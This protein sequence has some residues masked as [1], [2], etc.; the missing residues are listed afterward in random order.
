MGKVMNN[1]KYANFRYLLDLENF[2][3][4]EENYYKSIFAGMYIL[5]VLVKDGFAGLKELQEEE[6]ASLLIDI[7]KEVKRALNEDN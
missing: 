5:M 6:R 4:I 3:L 1:V 2:T 7:K